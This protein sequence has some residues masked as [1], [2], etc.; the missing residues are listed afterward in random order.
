MELGGHRAEAPEPLEEHLGRRPELI[1][2]E[3]PAAD[4]VRQELLRHAERRLERLALVVVPAMERRDVREAAPGEEA[5]HLELGVDAGLELA[6]HL[7][8]DRVVEHDRRVRLLDA[9]QADGGVGRQPRLGAIELVEAEMPVGGA[10][11]VGALDPPEQLERL[12]GLGKRVVH[13]P[14][15]GVRDGLPAFSPIGVRG[16][17]RERQLVELVRAG[18]EAGLD[19]REHEQRVI[20]ERDALDDVD[21]GD[22]ARLGGIPALLLDPVAELLLVEGPA[23]LLRGDLDAL[24]HRRAVPPRPAGTRRSHAGPSVS[25]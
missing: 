8:H 16:A 14:V 17:K 10:D 25:R 7:E 23:D 18:G 1:E 5:Q 6:E 15:G 24:T 22:V 2:C 20:A 4:R 12:R 3:L 11:L 21:P 13:G 9:H 19:E